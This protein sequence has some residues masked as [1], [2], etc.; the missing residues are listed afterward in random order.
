[1]RKI[2]ALLCTALV[3]ALPAAASAAAQPSAN[4]NGSLGFNDFNFGA[5]GTLFSADGHITFTQNFGGGDVKFTGRVN[6]LNIFLNRATLSGNITSVRPQIF[7]PANTPTDFF[8][9]AV[10]NGEPGEFRDQFF[11]T[12]FI[13]SPTFAPTCVA[14]LNVTPQTITDGN[15]DVD[16]VP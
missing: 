5:R 2:V 4:G 3:L 8:A 16:P 12:S 11:F 1:M 14:P 7:L 9:I 15:I 13:P 10:D 6:C